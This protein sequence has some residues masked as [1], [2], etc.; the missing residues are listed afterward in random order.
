MAEILR[1]RHD[2]E[3]VSLEARLVERSTGAGDQTLLLQSDGQIFSATLPARSSQADLL[4]GSRLQLTG[5]CVLEEVLHQGIAVVPQ[6]FRLLLRSPAHVLLLQAPPWWT[7][8]R[9][10]WA[11]GLVMA[12]LA[13]G[14]AWVMV[15]SKGKLRAHARSR[16]E[17]QA[18]YEAV[19][20][21]RNRLARELHD[22]LEQGLVGI[23]F[24][25]EASGKTLGKAPDMAQQ[26]LE[27][28]LRLVRKS[29]T[30]V[31]RS[32]WDLRAQV[33]DTA[34]LPSALASLGQQF[35]E[36]VPCHIQ[37]D[38]QGVPHR[39]PI[40]M[41][42]NLLRIC[43]EAVANAHKHAQARAISIR[44][45]YADK[46]VALAITDDGRGFDVGSAA[47]AA[48]GHFGLQGVRE[49]AGRIGGF[50]TIASTPGEGTR[51]A[52]E[53]PLAAENAAWQPPNG[54]SPPN[55]NGEPNSSVAGTAP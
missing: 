42:N 21:E 14:L 8:Q 39:L 24:Q 47:S 44:L 31:R 52:I 7:P 43:Q 10:L 45:S 35:N 5:I 49:R 2:A 18:R 23:A 38:V 46:L 27:L 25:L 33:L 6:S 54:D 9:I 15:R 28:A 50:L 51:V 36:G 22:S 40:V 12:L 1:G 19:L 16:A 29:H 55:F 48:Q 34:D 11:A 13:G 30:E 17:T 41:E 3:L 20:A 4:A 53:I 26:H 37:V 32:I